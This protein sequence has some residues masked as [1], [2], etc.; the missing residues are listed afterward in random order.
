MKTVGSVAN[1]RQDSMSLVTK[2]PRLASSLPLVVIKSNGSA[3]D[4]KESLV[5]CHGVGKSYGKASP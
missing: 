1:F 2:I 5:D 4:P 3:I